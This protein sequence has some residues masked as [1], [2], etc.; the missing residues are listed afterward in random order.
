MSNHI[1]TVKQ[2]RSQ[3]K[4]SFKTEP[5]KLEKLNTL[6]SHRRLFSDNVSLPKMKGSKFTTKKLITNDYIDAAKTSRNLNIN[7]VKTA[8][9]KSK[10]LIINPLQA[11]Y[12]PIGPKVENFENGLNIGKFKLD[13]TI[14]ELL[15]IL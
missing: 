9:K 10:N 7:Y 11:F 1:P 4:L 2:L 8:E 14:A 13:D 3:S 5:K 12:S 6:Q 15:R